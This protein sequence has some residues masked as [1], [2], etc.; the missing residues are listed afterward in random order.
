MPEPLLCELHAHTTWSDGVLA[1]P[2]LVDLYG[3]AGFDVLAVT[4]HVVRDGSGGLEAGYHRAY[5]EEI[6]LEADRAASLYGLLVV[7]GLELTYDDPDA[8][9]AAHALAVGVRAFVDVSGRLEAALATARAHGAAL[10]AAHPY[11]LGELGS[12]SRTTARWSEEPEWAAEVVDR[13]ELCNRHD[14]FAWVARERLPVVANGDFHRPEHLA[15]WKTLVPAEK[16]EEA[17][18]DYLRSRRPVSLALV[19]PPVEVIAR[20]A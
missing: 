4:D 15:T 5:L 3:R 9:R 14:F 19:E 7:P 13:F 20:A 1:P 11:E 16:T 18:V 17:V 8:R 2:E 6:E 12:T 10:I